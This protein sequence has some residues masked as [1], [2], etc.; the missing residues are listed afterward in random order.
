M[1]PRQGLRAAS[2]LNSMGAPPELH[3]WGCAGASRCTPAR[4]RPSLAP[5]LSH[6]L[7]RRLSTLTLSLS[8]FRLSP[9]FSIDRRGVYIDLGDTKT[10]AFCA[11][12]ELSL[13]KVDKVRET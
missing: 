4:R 3:A 13:V 2:P 7:D 10:P 12:S 1:A 5:I 6:A 9:L 11:V 8:L